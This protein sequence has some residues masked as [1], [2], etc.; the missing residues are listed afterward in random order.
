MTVA[1]NIEASRDRKFD[2]WNRTFP[3]MRDLW[4]D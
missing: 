3:G 4:V 1:G 2:D